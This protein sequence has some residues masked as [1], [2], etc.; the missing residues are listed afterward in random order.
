MASAEQLEAKGEG[1]GALDGLQERQQ[2]S[3]QPKAKLEG[4]DV[5]ELTQ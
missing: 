4:A 1:E 3:E 2:V 5:L